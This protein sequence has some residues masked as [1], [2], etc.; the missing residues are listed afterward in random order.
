MKT[1]RTVIIDDEPLA[2]DL[3][4]VLLAKQ[5]QIEVVACF[6]RGEDA[7]PYLRTKQVE[8]LFLDIEMPE[9]GGFEIIDAL[10]R[11]KLPATV[12]VTAYNE[13]AVKAFEVNAMD[14]LTKPIDPARLTRAVERVQDRIAADSALLTQEQFEA[15]LAS[16][17]RRSESSTCFPAHFFAKDGARDILLAADNIEWIEASE[18]YSCLHVLGHRYMVRQTIKELAARLD[19]QKF[20]RIHRSAIVSL[21]RVKEIVKDGAEDNYLVLH[22]GQKLKMSKIGRQRLIELVESSLTRSAL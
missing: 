5:S 9:V 7:L 2:V 8:L 6:C 14:Y 1:L 13:Y 20:V 11:E 19:P 4:R 17:K 10:G 21:S 18:Y 3:L 12:F 16:L 22:G 15:A